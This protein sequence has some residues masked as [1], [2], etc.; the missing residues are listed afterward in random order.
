M[1]KIDY[2]F[3]IEIAT[4]NPSQGKGDIKSFTF[5]EGI[6]P[7]YL[8]EPGDAYAL[9]YTMPNLNEQFNIRLKPKPKPA[10]KK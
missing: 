3:D 10:I 2:D 6:F 5:G 4:G 9:D 8:A 1:Q 7:A